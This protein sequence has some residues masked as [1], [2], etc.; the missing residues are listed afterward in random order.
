MGCKTC[1]LI[2]FIEFSVFKHYKTTVIFLDVSLAKS[3]DRVSARDR[4]GA[5]GPLGPLRCAAEFA[6]VPWLDGTGKPEDFCR[7]N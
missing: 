1:I 3:I 6:G 5:R 4:S 2:Q 7:A